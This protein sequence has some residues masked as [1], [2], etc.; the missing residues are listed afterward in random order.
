MFARGFPAF[1]A[2]Y[3]PRATNLEVADKFYI[4]QY[5]RWDGFSL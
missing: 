4:H 1:K 5:T 2:F 3:T